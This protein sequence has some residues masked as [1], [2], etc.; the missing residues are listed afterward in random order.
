MRSQL[1]LDPLVS[2]WGYMSFG[3]RNVQLFSI[4]RKIPEYVQ[5]LL[6]SYLLNRN[7][8]YKVFYMKVYQKNV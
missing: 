1:R 7:S 5:I 2:R 3:E 4:F 8:E 6:K